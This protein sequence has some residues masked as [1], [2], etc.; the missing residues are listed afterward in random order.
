MAFIPRFEIPEK[1]NKF[2]NTIS[3]GGYSTAIK[4]KPTEDGLDVLRNC[5]GYAFGRFNEIGNNSKMDKLQPI[6]AENWIEV[7]RKQGLAISQSPKLGA[8][9]CWQKG[10][11]LNSSDGAGHVAI[12]EKIY[13]ESMVLTSESGWNAAKPFWTQVR[14]K[15]TGNWGQP[16]GYIFRGF[17]LNPFVKDENLNPYK[18]PTNT[19]PTKISIKK[20]QTGESVKWLQWELNESGYLPSTTNGVKTIDGDFGTYTLAALLAF[21]F[22]HNLKPDGDCGSKTIAVLKAMH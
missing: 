5:V 11:T 21:Q 19:D 20:G 12:V 22:E 7:A 17:I 14:S 16:A 2:Y 3:N 8:V 10:S 18:E 13:S 1:G 4:G 6:N 9:M 15:G